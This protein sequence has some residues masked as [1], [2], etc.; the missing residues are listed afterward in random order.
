MDQC[1]FL[2]SNVLRNGG[3]VFN[4]TEYSIELEN[5]MSL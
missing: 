1:L 4:V 5:L 3:S 2:S